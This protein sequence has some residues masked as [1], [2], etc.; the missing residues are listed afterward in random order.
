MKSYF[1][2]QIELYLNFLQDVRKYSPLTIKTYK[3]NLFEAI[4]CVSIE[5]DDHRYEIDLLPYRMQLVGKNRKTI[6]KKVSIFRSFVNHLID[7]KVNIFLKNDENIKISK[8]LPKPISFK[9]IKE[10]LEICDSDDRLVLLLFYTLGLRVSELSNLKM[11]NIKNG[12]VKIY[13]KGGKIRQIPLLDEVAVELEEFLSKYQPEVYIFE[14]DRVKL[15]ENQLR[16]KLA[17][18]FKSIG[19]KATPHQLRH[20]YATDLLNQ[21]ARITDVS[22][23]LGH[24]SLETTQIYTKLSSSLKM[25]NYKKAHPMCRE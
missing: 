12:W 9:Y 6:Y 11:K 5:K 1:K 18:V 15:T 25:K 24:A 17:K 19:I 13:A 23:L 7:N 16:Y 8:T 2:E 4:E 21:G 20:S 3:L 14:N 10:A 22:E